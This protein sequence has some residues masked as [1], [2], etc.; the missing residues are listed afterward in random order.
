MRIRQRV[1]VEQDYWLSYCDK[2]GFL[3]VTE[4]ERQAFYLWDSQGIPCPVDNPIRWGKTRHGQYM[5]MIRLFDTL[6]EKE[7]WGWVNCEGYHEEDERLLIAAL[8]PEHAARGIRIAKALARV[9]ET[10]V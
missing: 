10:V 2:P 9:Q 7:G 3:V 8:G 5:G 1:R 4:E 6:S